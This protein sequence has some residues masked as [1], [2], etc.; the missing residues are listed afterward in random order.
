MLFWKDDKALK[1]SPRFGEAPSGVK[2]SQNG[3]KDHLEIIW[4]NPCSSRANNN[5]DQIFLRDENCQYPS[6][7]SQNVSSIARAQLITGCVTNTALLLQSQGC[8][9][10]Q[11][12]A[13]LPGQTPEKGKEMQQVHNFPMASWVHSLLRSCDNQK[14]HPLPS[15]FN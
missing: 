6:S 5:L 10:N 1:F 13:S 2:G 4:T 11:P 14:T 7:L 12:L 8:L 15:G 9:A 3:W